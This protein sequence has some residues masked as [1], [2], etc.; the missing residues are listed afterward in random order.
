MHECVYSTGICMNPRASCL[1]AQT[2]RFFESSIFF[3][4]VEKQIRGCSQNTSAHANTQIKSKCSHNERRQCYVFLHS[5]WIKRWGIQNVVPSPKKGQPRP[6]VLL[7]CSH[8]QSAETLKAL[9]FCVGPTAAGF[10]LLIVRSLER[11]ADGN[12]C[13]ARAVTSPH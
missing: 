3:C 10:K 12:E 11:N 13:G 5:S 4:F 6:L 7:I 8:K 2:S 9:S 1:S